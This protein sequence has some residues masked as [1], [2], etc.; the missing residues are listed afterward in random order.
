MTFAGADFDTSPSSSVA[1]AV[2]SYW[3]AGAFVQVKRYGALVEVATS[4][5]PA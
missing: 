4:R 1:T 3:P 2:I 5:L